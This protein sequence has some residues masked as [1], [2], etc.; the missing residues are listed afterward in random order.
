MIEDNKPETDTKPRLSSLSAVTQAFIDNNNYLKAFLRR[1]VQRSQDIED[2][3]QEA[4]IRAY[5]VEQK[6]G[7]DHPK[8]LI[9]TIA[10]NVALNELRT[11]A[12]RV[13]DYIE[14]SQA[15]IEPC[16]ASTEEEV[17]ALERLE[18]YCSAV[19]GLPEQCRRVYLLRKVHGLSHKGIAEQLG[20]TIR[21]V[22]RHLAKGVLKCRHYMREQDDFAEAGG[23]LSELTSATRH[24]GGIK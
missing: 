6:S 18:L 15:A 16:T 21:S 10:K 19:D 13:T 4:Y 3:A 17:V 8:T 14:E 11:K 2:I 7:I 12:R 23:H 20:I 24:Q 1:F 5:K 22:E 9:F